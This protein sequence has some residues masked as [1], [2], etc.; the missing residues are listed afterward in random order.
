MDTQAERT[1]SRA[2]HRRQELIHTSCR[3]ESSN[4]SLV[5]LDKEDG[6]QQALP[7]HHSR[8]ALGGIGVKF[9]IVGEGPSG[10]V[11]T[12]ATVGM[13]RKLFVHYLI[14]GLIELPQRPG[15]VSP[16]PHQV[17]SGAI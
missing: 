9:V 10:N 2:T 1:L 4:I 8:P 14:N 12:Q 5:V 3:S 15:S 7:R 11:A 6:S 17:D 13:G 16:A